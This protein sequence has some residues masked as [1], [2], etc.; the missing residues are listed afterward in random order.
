MAFVYLLIIV[1]AIGFVVWKMTQA[2]GGAP[3]SSGPQRDVP[4][5]PDDDPDFLGKL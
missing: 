5:G 3:T 2:Q 4:R 1:V